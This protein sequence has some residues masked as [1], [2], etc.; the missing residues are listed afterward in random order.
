MI[1]FN[2][3]KKMLNSI[4]NSKQKKSS[5]LKLFNPYQYFYNAPHSAPISEHNQ[6]KIVKLTIP[7]RPL[8][9][10]FGF[11]FG[12]VPEKTEIVLQKCSQIRLHYD[13]YAT[14]VYPD[15][16]N[17]W[18]WI[19]V[20]CWTTQDDFNESLLSALAYHA[21]KEQMKHWFNVLKV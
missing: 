4:F 12:S 15:S 18:S 19:T 13:Y 17:S 8:F 1:I 5:G 21:D 7:Q 10:I 16:N 11:S 14:V 20:A 9:S 6:F 3:N 2:E